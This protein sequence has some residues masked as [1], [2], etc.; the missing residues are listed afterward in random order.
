VILVAVFSIGF[1]ESS[2]ERE[3]RF[4]PL[5]KMTQHLDLEAG[6][7]LPT[8]PAPVALSSAREPVHIAN[9]SRLRSKWKPKVHPPRMAQASGQV[10]QFFETLRAELG[11]GSREH[12]LFV[13]W[14]NE[15]ND[16]RAVP[17]LID[18]REDEVRVYQDLVKIWYER[19]GW[20]WKFIPFYEVQGVEEVEVSMHYLE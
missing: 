13:C 1:F 3:G 8:I 15:V 14:G 6:I 2:L 9:Q 17:L 12:C 10:E 19:H 20:W 18:D 5:A 4:P 16:Q 7:E 11:S